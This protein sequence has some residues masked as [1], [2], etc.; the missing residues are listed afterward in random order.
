MV[1]GDCIDDH[2]LAEV[3]LVG[4]VVT[5]PGYHIK[6]G[7]ALP[8]G[9]NVGHETAVNTMQRPYLLSLKKAPLELVGD[10]VPIVVHFSVLKP[11]HRA[12]EVPWVGKTICSC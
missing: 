5:V 9:C 2:E 8:K 1:K 3:I 4:V 11:R 6:W 12:E 7:V 10:S